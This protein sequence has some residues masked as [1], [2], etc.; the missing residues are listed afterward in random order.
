MFESGC[1][2][3]EAVTRLENTMIVLGNLDTAIRR[4]DAQQRAILAKMAEIYVS[5][6][7]RIET[8]EAEIAELRKSGEE[9]QGVVDGLTRLVE[10]MQDALSNFEG[11]LG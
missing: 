11:G 10:Q 4:L 6:A 9:Q 2:I 8:L 3:I 7:R 5:Q 1:K